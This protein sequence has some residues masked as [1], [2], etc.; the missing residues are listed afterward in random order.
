[1]KT[2]S[3]H[4]L[5]NYVHDYLGRPV[6]M[7]KSNLRYEW[8]LKGSELSMLIHGR[9]AADARRRAAREVATVDGKRD[10]RRTLG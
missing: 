1:M 8:V 6:T 7:T 4:M 9:T 10:R 2:Y 5:P 3:T